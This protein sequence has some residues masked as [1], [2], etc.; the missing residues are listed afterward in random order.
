MSNKFNNIIFI[1]IILI[2]FSLEDTVTLNVKALTGITN[3]NYNSKSKKFTFDIGCNVDQNITNSIANIEI[4][5]KVKKH[6]EDSNEITA[7]CLISP[8]RISSST[9]TADTKLNCIIDTTDN[10]SINGNTELFFTGIPTVSSGNDIATFNFD[11]FD[12]ISIPIEISGLTLSYLDEDYCK[13]SNFIFQ[14]TSTDDFSDNSQLESTICIVALS[15]DDDHKEARCVIPMSG[16][17]MKCS[18]DVSEKKYEKGNTI[19]IKKQNLVSC[20]NGQ[21]LNILN[22]PTNTLTIKEEC[23]KRSDNSYLYINKLIF[24]LLLKLILF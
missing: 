18:V 7:T 1:I 11:K 17:K 19:T 8:V 13:N 15:N 23:S 10:P 21:I 16:V 4:Q 24:I 9:Q 12:E 20:E 2:S 6:P 3:S 14:M 22:D 5:V